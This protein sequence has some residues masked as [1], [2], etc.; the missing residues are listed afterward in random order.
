MATEGTLGHNSD[1][2]V[3]VSRSVSIP[4]KEVWKAL[5]SREG[6]EAL[7]GAGGEL[8]NKGDDW[9]ADDGTFGVMRSYHP[10]E[11]VRFTWHA[12][13]GAPRT[14]VNVH[15]QGVPDGGT[16]VEIRHE[17]VPH[18][19]DKTALTARWETFLDKLFALAG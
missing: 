7:L 4:V 12:A 8:G 10:L 5:A 15:L 9:H 6:G 16:S 2:D 13:E 17:R 18:Y 11:E 1:T 3:I 19:F 14:V